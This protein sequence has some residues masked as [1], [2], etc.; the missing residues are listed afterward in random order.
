MGAGIG[1]RFGQILVVIVVQAA[2]LFLAFGGIR[3][4]AAWLYLGLYVAFIALT[5]RVVL[6]VNPGVVAER[7]EVRPGAK[8]W[9]L[10]IGLVMA[11]CSLG[12]LVVAGLD[13]RLDWSAVAS[14]PAQLLGLAAFILGNALFD[15]AMASNPFFSTVVRIQKERGHVVVTAGPYRYV[16]HPGYVGQSIAALATPLLLGSRWGLVPAVLLLG[17]ILLRTSLE[18]RTLRAELPGYGEYAR[19][20]RYRLVPGLW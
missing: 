8:E 11:V 5:A 7:A 20:V 12:I 6:R 1:K 4:G 19:R 15:W 10:R 14:P 9:D 16:R 13:R 3:W 17:V 2:A 18:D